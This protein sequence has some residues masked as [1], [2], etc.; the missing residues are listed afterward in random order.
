MGRPSISRTHVRKAPKAARPRF[1]VAPD[2]LSPFTS[3]PSRPLVARVRLRRYSSTKPRVRS[4]Q[5]GLPA[6]RASDPDGGA[7]VLRR[8]VYMPRR[9]GI[10]SSRTA[11]Y[12]RARRDSEASI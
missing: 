3:R 6:A 8:R 12:R 5:R 10:D 4:R 7:G 1:I 11:P 2:M 9:R